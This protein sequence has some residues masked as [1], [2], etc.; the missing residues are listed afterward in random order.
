MPC[1]LNMN[2]LPKAHAFEHLPAGWRVLFGKLMEPSGG[3]AQ[4]ERVG[5]WGQVLL[6][7][8]QALLPDR[9]CNVT[10]RPLAFYTRWNVMAV[11]KLRINPP[12]L[13]FLLGR[14]FATSLSKVVM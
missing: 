3:R 13:K 6:F 14:R 10:S 7:S 2:C 11:S 1:G 8:S 4:L 12:F 9:G 5:H